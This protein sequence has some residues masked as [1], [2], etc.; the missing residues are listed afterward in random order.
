MSS[1]RYSRSGAEALLARRGEG[2]G[3]ARCYAARPQELSGRP[4]LRAAM[5]QRNSC[6]LWPRPLPS[7]PLSKWHV[8]S[9][10]PSMS[11]PVLAGA[12]AAAEPGPVLLSRGSRPAV[13]RVASPNTEALAPTLAPASRCSRG[14]R[15]S[16][17]EYEH[18]MHA[19]T[20]P[21]I[22]TSKN[23]NAQFLRT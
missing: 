14:A 4:T 15:Q 13:L 16:V 11:M 20:D 23:A 17:G 5:P 22:S 6:S 19:G 21:Q 12:A 8:D 9:D 10:A 7:G 3:R 18:S 2:R 1:S